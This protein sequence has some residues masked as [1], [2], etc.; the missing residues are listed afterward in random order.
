MSLTFIYLDLI[1]FISYNFIYFIIS[2]VSIIIQLATYYKTLMNIYRW[3]YK[4]YRPSLLDYDSEY[5]IVQYE[6]ER[7]IDIES[8]IILFKMVSIWWI[9]WNGSI[10]N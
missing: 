8:I 10:D 5:R 1:L 6:L 3:I 7:G 2:C 9:S 4:Y